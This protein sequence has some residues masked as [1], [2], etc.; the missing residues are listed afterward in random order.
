VTDDWDGIVAAQHGDHLPLLPDPEIQCSEVFC[1]LEFHG[2][3]SDQP[4]R[5]GDAVELFVFTVDLRHGF[6]TRE[7]AKHDLCL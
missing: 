2:Q 5:F 1:N 4:L 3:A 7:Q 6:G